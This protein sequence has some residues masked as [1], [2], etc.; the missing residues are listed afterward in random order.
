MKRKVIAYKRHAY[1]PEQLH[2]GK[3]IVVAVTYWIGN[4]VNGSMLDR[5]TL[6]NKDSKGVFDIANN[7]YRIDHPQAIIHK[8][9]PEAID[10]SDVLDIFLVDFPP[11]PSEVTSFHGWLSP[12]GVFYKCYYSEHASTARAICIGI[13]KL[14]S[15]MP[16]FNRRKDDYEC[17]LESHGWGRVYENGH[18][19]IN[20]DQATHQQCDS[21]QRAVDRAKDKKFV[22]EDSKHDQFCKDRNNDWIELVES[23]I[24]NFREAISDHEYQVGKTAEDFKAGYVT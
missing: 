1:K 7:L 16:E 21:L 24:S 15:D 6:A 23:H 8:E 19:T 2:Y 10:A 14:S 11:D 3:F 22:S 13:L 4:E 5:P 20:Y 17:Y 18:V 9:Y 12:E